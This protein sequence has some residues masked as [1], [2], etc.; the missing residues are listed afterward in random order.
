MSEYPQRRAQPAKHFEILRA[1]GDFFIV[2]CMEIKVK[3][4]MPIPFLYDNFTLQPALLG[5]FHSSKNI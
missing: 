5:L 4:V 3:T 1:L 2:S